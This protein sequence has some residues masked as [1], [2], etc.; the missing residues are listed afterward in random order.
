[1][2]RRTTS[3][4]W[5]WIVCILP[6]AL[7]AKC[8][9]EA[10]AGAHMRRLQAPTVTSQDSAIT[11]TSRSREPGL[12]VAS[13]WPHPESVLTWKGSGGHRNGARIRSKT[14]PGPETG[15][16]LGPGW[17]LCHLTPL[18]LEC[19]SHRETLL[20]KRAPVLYSD[21]LQPPAHVPP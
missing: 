6:W 16:H 15:T 18:I 7:G 9:Q 5:Q 20:P 17:E 3:C 11:I 2:T 19:C 13:V 1:M 12:P 21:S 10:G 14:C 4:D 8:G